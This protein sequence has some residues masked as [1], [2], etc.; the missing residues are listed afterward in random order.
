MC[1]SDLLLA[2]VITFAESDLYSLWASNNANYSFGA[3][4]DDG[5]LIALIL[6]CEALWHSGGEVE[7]SERLN[8][9]A[10]TISLLLSSA[11]LAIAALKPNYFP[12]FVLIPGF[13]TIILA[14]I[15]MSIAIRDARSVAHEREL[16][17]TDELTGD[18]K[19]TR[20]NSS[21]T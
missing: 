19:S 1:S 15:R 9:F 21:H 18:R 20:L 14:F 16:A 6:I 17:R 4:T 3:L 5:W 8:T 11:V 13:A 12:S 10:T 7:V 2:G